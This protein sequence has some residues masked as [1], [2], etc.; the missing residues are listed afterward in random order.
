MLHR[1]NLQYLFSYLGLIPFIFI[2]FNKYFL[3]QINQEISN[4]FVVY[5]SILIIVFIGALNWNLD[6]KVSNLKI[7]YGFLPSLFG[8]C[9]IIMNLYT[10]DFDIIINILIL[11]FMLQLGFDYFFI[12]L[13]KFNKDP[14][15][16]LRLPLTILITLSL[17][18]IKF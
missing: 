15:L 18:I 4:N 12:N 13:K 11:F 5:Y 6:E 7:I 10:Y 17:I 14:F 16:F 9:V 1:F 2:I 3:L 8:V